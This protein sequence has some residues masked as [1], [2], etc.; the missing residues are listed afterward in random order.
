MIDGHLR[1]AVD[2]VQLIFSVLSHG[3]KKFAHHSF[4]VSDNEAIALYGIIFVVHLALKG[5]ERAVLMWLYD[6][7]IIGIAVNKDVKPSVALLIV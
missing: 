1:R 4:G 3:I 6:G 2:S 5:V 7:S